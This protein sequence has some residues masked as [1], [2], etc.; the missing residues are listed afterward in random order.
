MARDTRSHN[1]KQSPDVLAELLGPEPLG[2]EAPGS[3]LPPSPAPDQQPQVTAPRAVKTQP[4][5]GPRP[6]RV[7]QPV[8]EV[9]PPAWETEI[10]TF[11]DHRGWRP[12][13][14]D[15]VEVQSW[16]AGPLIHDYLA[17]RGAGGWE[18]AGATTAA[19]FYGVADSL[20]LYFKRRK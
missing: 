3:Q 20:Q 8:L 10:V 12:R 9:A 5:A 18:L 7:P 16:L 11:Q 4:P 2:H 17:E 6:P 15:G 13:Y 1:R 19:H 14:V